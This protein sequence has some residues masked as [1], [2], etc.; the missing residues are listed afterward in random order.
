MKLLSLVLAAAA[1]SFASAKSAG[2]A[3][4]DGL[5]TVGKTGPSK[6]LSQSEE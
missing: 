3:F 5:V 1:A 2:W 4:S 6:A